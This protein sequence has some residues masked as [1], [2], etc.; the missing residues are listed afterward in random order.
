MTYQA[1]GMTLQGDLVG[2]GNGGDG[3]GKKE[4]P[5]W[6]TST[7]PQATYP[8]NVT[9]A[10]GGSF[11]SGGGYSSFPSGA[12]P[13]GYGS[14]GGGYGGGGY[15]SGGGGYAAAAA[16]VAA[17]GPAKNYASDNPDVRDMVNAYKSRLA[18]LQTRPAM[19]P[20]YT[21]RATSA[22]RGEIMDQA[23]GAEEG[24]RQRAVAQGRAGGGALPGRQSRISEA[25]SRAANK[26]ASDISLARTRDEEQNAL[27]RDAMQNS[28]TLGGAGIMSAPAQLGLQQQG[29]GLQQ[30]LGLGNLALGQGNLALSRD[31]FS[32]GRDDS[33][34]ANLLGIMRT[35]PQ[36]GYAGY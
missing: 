19:D 16:P 21:A 14:A 33:R 18:T 23:A 8:V 4:K 28:F 9:P 17:A 2:G 12:L 15:A 26:A 35:L 13:P 20:T 1:G 5:A 30:E 36:Y 22:A 24:A 6:K 10:G 32:A 29:L 34:L 7:G 25:A 11:P 27:T 31:Q 3:A